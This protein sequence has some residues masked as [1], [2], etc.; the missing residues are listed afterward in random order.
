MTFLSRF[1]MCK[2]SLYESKYSVFKVHVGATWNS[3]KA[4]EHQGCTS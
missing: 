1:S 2:C 4:M 3:D